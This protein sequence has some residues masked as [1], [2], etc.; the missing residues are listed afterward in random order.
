MATEPA[1]GG[2]ASFGPA[3]SVEMWAGQTR[4]RHSGSAHPDPE[5]GRFSKVIR[6]KLVPSTQA[7]LK[8]RLERQYEVKSQTRPTAT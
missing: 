6:Q 4:P 7:E 3:P 8:L 2:G 5:S 1:R